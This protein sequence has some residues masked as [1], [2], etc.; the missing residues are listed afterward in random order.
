MIATPK[1]YYTAILDNQHNKAEINKILNM[2]LRDVV[3]PSSKDYEFNYMH[4]CNTAKRVGFTFFNDFEL[5][6]L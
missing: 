1:Q 4:L 2:A 6:T 3:V 5:L